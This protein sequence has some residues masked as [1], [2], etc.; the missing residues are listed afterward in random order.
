VTTTI[1]TTMRVINGVH[2][3]TTNARTLAQVTGTTS[4]ADFHILMLFVA[5][6]AD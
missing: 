5:D 4:L 6:D 3:N 2:N 1:T